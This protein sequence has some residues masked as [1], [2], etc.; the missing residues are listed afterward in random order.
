[1]TYESALV[2]G[3]TNGIGCATAQKLGERGI[4]SF[5]AGGTENAATPW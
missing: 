5:S 1:M 2:T 4:T 3:A